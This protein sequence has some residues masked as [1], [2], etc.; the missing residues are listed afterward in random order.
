MS[1]LQDAITGGWD[2]V[3][4][5][6]V[7]QLNQRIAQAWGDP[8]GV[9]ISN[10]EYDA[11]ATFGAWRIAPGGGS[12]LM[13]V[14]LP[15]PQAS[16]AIKGQPPVSFSGS[17]VVA[18][19]L[20]YFDQVTSGGSL[21]LQIKQSGS[22]RLGRESLFEI[23]DLQL[24]AEA[25]V[26]SR[27]FFQALLTDWLSANESVFGDA[28]ASIDMASFS[29]QSGNSWLQPTAIDYAI[30]PGHSEQE[31][32][33]AV[34][35][36]TAGRPS[37]G[38]LHS[39]SPAA[40]P[41]TSTG[42][43]LLSPY[44]LLH[45][46]LLHSVLGTFKE[47]SAADFT[48][49]DDDLS[50]TLVEP[51][52]LNPIEKD[53]ET[54]VATLKSFRIR[55]FGVEIHCSATT[56]VAVTAGVT[57]HTSVDSVH[58]FGIISAEDGSQALA[59][60]EKTEPKVAHWNEQDAEVSSKYD[61]MG[62]SIVAATIV[63]SIA[64]GGIAG[65]LVAGAGALVGGVVSSAPTFVAAWTLETAPSLDLLAMNIAKPFQWKGGSAFWIDSVD[66]PQSVRLA[67]TPWP[68]I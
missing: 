21:S 52:E 8:R 43:I 33:L 48:I 55:S 18:V 16:V 59:F 10:F 50:I 6:R 44:L 25:D 46:I 15:I 45:Q 47:L 38:K 68:K 4:A 36:M 51:R 61:A 64:T 24:S 40:V 65:I 37:L 5:I 11:S 34:L 29:K 41:G 32:L 2:V 26:F 3:Y 19:E 42:A 35:G 62:I 58:V 39:V 66:M 22:F 12:H 57:A 53:G 56:S 67:G 20:E 9:N 13:N 14:V 63:A 17:V 23:L 60:V 30:A 27:V 49:N 7:D 1:E 54:Y 28:L 31:T